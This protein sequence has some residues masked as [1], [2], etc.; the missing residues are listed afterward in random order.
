MDGWILWLVLVAVVV[1]VWLAIE[2][3]LRAKARAANDPNAADAASAPP[4]PRIVPAGSRLARLRDLKEQGL[5][6]QEEHDER[7]REV[8][9]NI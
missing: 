6:T 8:L 1:V 5:I 4:T 9:R 7:R 3:H 2:A